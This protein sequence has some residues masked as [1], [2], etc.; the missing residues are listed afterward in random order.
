MQDSGAGGLPG[1]AAAGRGDT[2]KATS[3]AADKAGVGGRHGKRPGVRGRIAGQQETRLASPQ[4]WGGNTGGHE[5]SGV[6]HGYLGVGGEEGGHEAS[7][8]AENPGGDRQGVHGGVK[9]PQ[10]IN[11]HGVVE[12]PWGDETPRVTTEDE[13]VPVE[14]GRG[15]GGD[16]NPPTT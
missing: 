11:T 10:G 13:L 2:R 14:D 15:Q 8:V 7:R 6:A 1:Y 16:G 12:L 4:E 5:A 3:A 9:S